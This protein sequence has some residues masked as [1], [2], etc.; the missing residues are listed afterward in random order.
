MSTNMFCNRSK[1]VQMHIS[2]VQ[3]YLY[4]YVP[5]MYSTRYVYTYIYIYI[6]TYIGIHRG[7]ET[8]AHVG[9]SDYISIHTYIRAQSVTCTER[10]T[11]YPKP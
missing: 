11:V 4:Q 1:Y 10:I 3:A 6:Y 2:H 8:R 9:K 5:I 7:R